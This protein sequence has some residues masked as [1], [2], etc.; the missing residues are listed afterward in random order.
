M[1]LLDQL[2]RD[3]TAS[4]KARDTARTS[5]LRMAKAAVHN[6]EIEARQSLADKEEAEIV[7]LQ[8]YLPEAGSGAEIEAVLNEWTQEGWTLDNIQFAMRESSKRPA[9][10]FIAFTREV[11]AGEAER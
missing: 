1:S 5:V 9:M 2:G 7:V 3:L 8:G 4:M 10:A 6:R 11:G